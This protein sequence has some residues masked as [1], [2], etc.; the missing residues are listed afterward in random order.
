MQTS[1]V[2]TE[3]ERIKIA[4]NRI[5]LYYMDVIHYKKKNNVKTFVIDSIPGGQDGY[6]SLVSIEDKYDGKSRWRDALGMLTEEAEW[7]TLS[8][9]TVAPFKDMGE[10]K[11]GDYSVDLEKVLQKVSTMLIRKGI[12]NYFDGPGVSL[13]NYFWDTDKAWLYIVLL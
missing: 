8:S 13:Q 4:A 5:F 2:L 11:N 1:Q 3:A 10:N 6:I 9:D 12:A 7:C